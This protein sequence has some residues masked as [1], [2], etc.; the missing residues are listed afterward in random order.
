[1]ACVLFSTMM[2][3]I[4]HYWGT[5]LLIQR[6]FFF[7]VRLVEKEN[8]D[9]VE[10]DVK[11]QYTNKEKTA[12]AVFTLI[13]IFSIIEIILAAAIAAIAKSSRVL[14]QKPQQPLTY[15]MHYQVRRPFH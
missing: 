15:N 5:S 6:K 10:E 9:F 2:V 7:D 11:F 3:Y 12:L 1:M 14:Y 13:T 4:Y 8:R